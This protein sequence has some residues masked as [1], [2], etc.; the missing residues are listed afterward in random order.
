MDVQG[1]KGLDKLPEEKPLIWPRTQEKK[2]LFTVLSTGKK[3]SVRELHDGF[4][5]AEN[6]V[7]FTKSE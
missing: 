2:N 5:S 1:S 6:P 7:S 4:P 3:K